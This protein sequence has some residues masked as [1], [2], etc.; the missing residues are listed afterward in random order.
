MK[1]RLDIL[2]LDGDTDYRLARLA[3]LELYHTPAGPAATAV[4]ETAFAALTDGATAAPD[5]LAVQGRSVRV[6]RAARG[7][8]WFGFVELCAKPLGPADFLAIATH[9]HTVVVAD[10]PRFT[11]DLHNET[12]RFTTLVDALYEHR[13]ALVMSAADTPDRLCVEGTAA[14]EFRRTASRLAEMRSRDYRRRS[15]LT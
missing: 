10:V 5:T 14:F 11:P 4:L 8:A 3:D 9:F 2:E 13:T 15:H 7:V 6:P 1:Q 12:R